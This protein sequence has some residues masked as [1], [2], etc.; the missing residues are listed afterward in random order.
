M[1]PTD[2]TDTPCISI[3]QLDATETWCI[4]CGR[5][6]TELFNWPEKSPQE[7]AEIISRARQRLLSSGRK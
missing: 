7:R 4:G 5:L 3:C 1:E 6:R 2:R